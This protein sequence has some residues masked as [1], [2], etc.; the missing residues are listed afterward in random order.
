MIKYLVLILLITGVSYGQGIYTPKGVTIIYNQS[1]DLAPRIFSITDY[2]AVN[3][4]TV[5]S[6]VS[7]QRTI[8]SADRYNGIVFFPPGK[9]TASA[10]TLPDSTIIQGYGAKLNYLAGQT[11]SLLN[12]AA[13]GRVRIFGLSLDGG[14]YTY[15][16]T[17]AEGNRTGITMVGATR[18]HFENISVK[19][20]NKYGISGS[21]SDFGILTNSYFKDNYVSMYFASGMEYWSTTGCVTQDGKYGV[22]MGAGNNQF[23]NCVFE[24]AVYGAYVVQGS[25]G[26]HGGFTGCTFNHNTSANLYVT[27]MDLPEMFVSCAFYSGRVWVI[28]SEG[29]GMGWCQ[30]GTVDIIVDNADGMLKDCI[31]NQSVTF[32]ELNAGTMGVSG[33]IN[34]D[35]T[36]VSWND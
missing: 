11:A 9:Y 35:G 3:D 2:G 4:S 5:N 24:S 36:A 23:T 30:F 15:D 26:A 13:S 16:S 27:G 19:G 17:T 31:I 33:N 1:Y 34:Q 6:T 12:I 22:F 32:T 29:F 28:N 20:F 25:N 18:C 10:L 8:D 21:T 7:I 14:N